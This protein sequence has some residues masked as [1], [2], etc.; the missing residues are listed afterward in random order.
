[1]SDDYK[2]AYSR[3]RNINTLD[4]GSYDD[5]GDGTPAKQVLAKIQNLDLGSDLNKEYDVAD[6]NVSAIRAIYKTINGI[7]HGDPDLTYA[8][9][10][11]IGISITGALSGN[12]VK[13]QIDGRLEDSSFNFPLNDPLFLGTDGV[14]TNTPPVTGHN[15]RLGLSLGVGAIQIEI[16][17]P[18][19]L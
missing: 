3:N 17:M 1:M 2:T 12:T 18:I 4:K 5:W 13:Y 11:I 16:Q 7:A 15:T 19:I 14:I 8:E 9:A 6:G 10:S